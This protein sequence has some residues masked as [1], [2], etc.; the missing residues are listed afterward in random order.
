MDLL[1]SACLAEICRIEVVLVVC[2]VGLTMGKV[3]SSVCECD[4]FA[5]K[6]CNKYQSALEPD[7]ELEDK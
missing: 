3:I 4:E 1:P 6:E 7:S 2:S 5:E